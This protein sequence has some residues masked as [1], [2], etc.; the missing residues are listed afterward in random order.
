[1]N[2]TT[3]K[4][5]TQVLQ[6]SLDLLEAQHKA[7][8]D[9]LKAQAADKELIAAREEEFAE[10]EAKLR[11][12]LALLEAPKTANFETTHS[13][14]IKD[15][16]EPSF[17]FMHRVFEA[18]MQ[19]GKS[20]FL[21]I[22]DN[23]YRYKFEP[24]HT[25]LAQGLMSADDNDKAVNDAFIRAAETFKI[26]RAF[27]AAG[28][29][30][31]SPDSPAI[32]M[33]IPPAEPI[34]EP[35]PEAKLKGVWE[36]KVNQRGIDDMVPTLLAFGVPFAESELEALSPQFLHKI[37]QNLESTDTEDV[38]MRERRKAAEQKISQA[39]RTY[40]DSPSEP[41]PPT[42]EQ[43]PKVEWKGF[44]T[45]DQINDMIRELIAA[46]V[47]LDKLNLN[48][49]T[50]KVLAQVMA[51]LTDDSQSAVLL[52]ADRL[53]QETRLNRIHQMWKDGSLAA[54]EAQA[55]A[56]QP[57]A[58][59]PQAQPNPF[60]AKPQPN[61]ETFRP[62][63]EPPKP[64]APKPK[65]EVNNPPRNDQERA[66]QALITK[67][68]EELLALAQIGIVKGFASD[69]DFKNSAKFSMLQ[70]NNFGT[71]GRGDAER[72]LR[73][74]LTTAR[75]DIDSQTAIRKQ[76]DELISLAKTGIM[77]DSDLKNSSE[78]EVLQ[79]HNFHSPQRGE[80][81]RWLKDNLK[82]A[83]QEFSKRKAVENQKFKL[84]EKMQAVVE[85]PESRLFP[86][87]GSLPDYY[88]I[89]GVDRNA[90]TE[91][92]SK[93]YRELS[94]KYHPDLNKFGGDVT[95]A[96]NDARDLLIDKDKKAEY[97]RALSTR[98][99]S[100]FG[101]A[102]GAYSRNPNPWSNPPRNPEPP[103]PR[104]QDRRYDQRQT[105]ATMEQ[106]RVDIFNASSFKEITVAL[107]KLQALGQKIRN[108]Q[109]RQDQEPAEIVYQ[110]DQLWRFRNMGHLV[111]D[112]LLRQLPKEFSIQSKA[113]ELINKYLKAL[114]ELN[115]PNAKFN[116]VRSA[117]IMYS[118]FVGTTGYGSNGVETVYRLQDIVDATD[119]Y[120]NIQSE[121]YD[122]AGANESKSRQQDIIKTASYMNYQ[123]E[124]ISP[125]FDLDLKFLHFFRFPPRYG[126]ETRKTFRVPEF[127]RERYFNF[128]STN[129]PA[130]YD[131]ERQLRGQGF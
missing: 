97:D 61:P 81:I 24:G 89:L 16:S 28:M 53:I 100:P 85:L 34:K 111:I 98:A 60:R 27:H 92:I 58:P 101:Q 50:D 5:D 108:S 72:W 82:A 125:S 15:T 63:P 90:T 121:A 87:G 59:E 6:R 86:K 84:A 54:A 45:Q 122:L 124:D 117:L 26:E 43:K 12:D 40:Q 106:I 21:E 131:K 107:D 103:R 38:A 126:D 46:E 93:A 10:K 29:P 112:N 47:K 71:P 73:D 4:V 75:K 95:Q 77:S 102:A 51:E 57:P 109:T 67:Q 88:L 31:Q 110:L 113:K 18:Q 105:E 37:E 91:E 119:K 69:N 17:R 9:N 68:V 14:L 116:T 78:F 70:P 33:G 123:L 39:W 35:A 83:Q 48:T 115:T 128:L 23:H 118:R 104:Q 49:L 11:N 8:I 19:A 62:K 129:F 52:R 44:L 127:L 1:M 13:D 55:R 76:V 36:S 120:L 65:P 2:E 79:T 94:R 74:T 99:Y 41:A 130:D 30:N 96:L 66:R 80:A 22:G 25:N 3:V 64:E 32:A 42:P 56:K 114:N 20:I 7:T